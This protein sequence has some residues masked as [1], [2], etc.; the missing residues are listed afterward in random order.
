MKLLI[1]G[2]A[3]FIGAF[4]AKELLARGHTVVAFDNFDTSLYSQ[5]LKR[6]RVAQVIGEHPNFSLIT[7]DILD[8]ATLAAAFAP[9]PDVVIH[10]AGL[11]NPGLSMSMR[12]AYFAS[13]VEGTANV[14]QS[15]TK[16][17]TSRLVFAGSSSVYNDEVVP[18]KEESNELSPRS[19]YG[20][21]KAEAEELITAWQQEQPNRFA[22]IL[23]FFSV[24]GPWGR[25]D[26]APH[27]FA[28]KILR[29]EV[30]EVT[31]EERK[32]DF[33]Y[34]DD[35]VGGI[36]A[37]VERPFPLE[38]INLGRGEP[39]TLQGLIDAL[40]TAAGATPK[41]KPRPTPPGEMRVTYAD[42]SKA[43]R[44][45]DY[46]PQVS[47]KEGAQKLIEWFKAHPEFVQE[48]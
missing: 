29:G 15:M 16:A 26:M 20:Q 37:A 38:I 19:P 28:Q 44:L 12:E 32:R 47:V 45:L 17:Q 36:V 21:S 33:T 27:L 11:A 24:Y 25:P 30:L 40:A 41:I 42:I 48:A 2:G 35:T 14:L 22:T 43:E 10:L 6:A 5:A 1:T 18:F 7:G 4:V 13:N 3:G 8:Q 31:Q 34:I 46:H 39:T 23:R 9:T